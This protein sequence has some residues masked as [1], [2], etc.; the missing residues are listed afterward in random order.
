MKLGI[1]NQFYNRFE[2]LFGSSFFI[3]CFSRIYPYHT[4]SVGRPSFI[5][6]LVKVPKYSSDAHYFDSTYTVIK[7]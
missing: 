7:E 2:I 4:H 1:A 5:I 3:N 6:G